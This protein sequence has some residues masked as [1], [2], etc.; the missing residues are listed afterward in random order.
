M[1]TQ[2]TCKVIHLKYRVAT[3]RKFYEAMEAKLSPRP[4]TTQTAGVPGKASQ[5]RTMASPIPYSPVSSFV[6]RKRFWACC[7][8]H[9]P[10]IGSCWRIRSLCFPTN[11]GYA[12][13][14]AAMVVQ[15]YQHDDSELN[16][17]LQYK[18]T[19]E[20]TCPHFKDA[21]RWSFT[22]KAHAYKVA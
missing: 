22:S 13:H 8:T 9:C 6:V 4:T 17:T 10:G 19:Y 14:F 12:T 1:R 3:L 11:K 18:S 5:L 20:N 16:E 2:V 21:G 7:L 15:E